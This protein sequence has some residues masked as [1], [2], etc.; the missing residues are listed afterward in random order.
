MKRIFPHMDSTLP[1]SVKDS[2]TTDFK[3][4]DKTM[5]IISIIS[6][7]IVASI[8]ASVNGTYKLGIFG[9][10][11]ALAITLIAYFMFKGTAFSRILFGIGLMIYPS[12]MVQQQLGMIEMHFGYF[13][14]AA[15]LAMYKDITPQLSA[16]TAVAVHHL[17]FTY[18]QLNGA[19][20][21]GEQIILFSGTCS[22]SITFLHV[23]LWVFELIGLVYIIIINTKQFIDGKKLEHEASENIKKMEQEQ[24]S[25][26]E[27]IDETINVAKEIQ[28]GKLTNRIKS[29]T[30]DKNIDNLK[31]VINEMLDNLNKSVGTNINDTLN[32]LNNFAKLNFINTINNDGSKISNSLQNVQ[33]LVTE[34]LVENKTNG[35]TLQESSNTLLSNVD[36]LT[37]SSNEAAA[38]LEETAAALEEITSSIAHN[39]SNIV[40]MASNSSSLTSLANEGQNMAK[41]TTTAMDQID[42]EV[43]AINEAITVIDQIAF[44]TNILSLNAAVEAATAGEAG[45]GFAV[46]AQEVRNLASRSAEAANEIKTL[47][48]AAT[49]KA[50][51]GKIIADKMISG[52]T[53]LNENIAKT[54]SLISD[55]ENSSK[56]QKTSI[57]QINSA[58]NE[59]DAQTQKNANTAN[60]T[61]E[62]A[63]QTD[64]ISKTIVDSADTKEFEGKNNI[65]LTQKVSPKQ[66]PQKVDDS[67]VTSSSKTKI[68]PITSKEAD[69]EWAS[70]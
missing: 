63:I 56:E 29:T 36:E 16:A 66:T 40:Q 8:S 64:T 18:L 2:L 46:V 10:G 4:A 55:I 54:A 39:T 6:F 50:N 59:L 47:V 57:E 61:R 48:E 31:N 32:T 49:T 22:W 28:D 68:E 20:F 52:Y 34:M 11:T 62:I 25:N 65:K 35:I 17:L 42:K 26:K 21:M 27:I 69:D 19:S 43:N 1:Q 7:L 51:S 5:L 30:S 44:Q 13:F 3:H 38:S 14:M 12:L 9:G 15:F 70:F 67:I 60:Q 53:N 23:I 41:E 24:V 45:K 37:K 58:I 33:K